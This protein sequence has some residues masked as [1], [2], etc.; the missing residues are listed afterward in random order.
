MKPAVCARC[1]KPMEGDQHKAG[2]FTYGDCCIFKVLE[3][4]PDLKFYTE[5]RTN[6]S[7][8]N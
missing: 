1:T 4:H 2:R 6:D 5:K 8:G 3:Q 7:A